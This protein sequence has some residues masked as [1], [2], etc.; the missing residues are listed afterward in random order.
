[1][2]FYDSFLNK[3]FL[4]LSDD[5]E[6][7]IPAKRDETNQIVDR[8]TKEREH[9]LETAFPIDPL[10]GTSH[11]FTLEPRSE[12]EQHSIHTTNSGKCGSS[13]ASFMTGECLLNLNL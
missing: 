2:V 3:I 4:G 7:P 10:E 11:E 1:M 9:R 13:H 6:N 8:V 12:C 5:V